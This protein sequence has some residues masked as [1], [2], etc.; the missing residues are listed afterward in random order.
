MKVAVMKNHHQGDQLQSHHL[1]AGLQHLGHA[2]L[3]QLFVMP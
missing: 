2:A 3:I 1:E